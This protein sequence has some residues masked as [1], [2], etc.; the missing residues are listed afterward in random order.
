VWNAAN[1]GFE[2]ALEG[3]ASFVRDAVFSVDDSFVVTGSADGTA[4]VW[5]LARGKTIG[6]LDHGAADV[7]HVE[8]SA[9]GRRLITEAVDRVRVWD[10]SEEARPADAVAALVKKNVPWTLVEGTAVPKR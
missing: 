3:H 9:D 6:V 10:L 1:G 4:R 7:H 5:D 8:L 2:I